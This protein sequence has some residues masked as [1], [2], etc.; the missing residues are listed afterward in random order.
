[1]KG[2]FFSDDEIENGDEVMIIVGIG[3]ELKSDVV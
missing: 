1:M 2:R 3:T